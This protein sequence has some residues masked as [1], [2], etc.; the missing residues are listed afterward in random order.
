M[1]TV[2]QTSLRILIVATLFTSSVALAQESKP[3]SEV[4]QPETEAL[5]QID[6]IS[7]SLIQ[8]LRLQLSNNIKNQVNMALVHSAEL[9]KKSL[10][11]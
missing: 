5:V 6:V 9:I 8:E 7:D 3:D 4:V 11:Q 1:K 10:S 2:K